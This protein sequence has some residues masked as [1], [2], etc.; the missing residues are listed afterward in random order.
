M[1]INYDAE[2]DLLYFR[3]D[4]RR[5]EVVNKQV[6]ED[7]VLDVGLDNKIIGIEI[8][9]ASEHLDLSHLLPIDRHIAPSAT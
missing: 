4:P 5:Q 7:V 3:F 2:L 8:L 9:S 6:A 1:Q